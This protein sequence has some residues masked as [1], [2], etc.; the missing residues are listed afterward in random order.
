M[1]DGGKNSFRVCGVIEE[2]MRARNSALGFVSKFLSLP[3]IHEIS[4][5]DRFL[6]WDSGGDD[7]RDE[8]EPIRVGIVSQYFCSHPIGRLSLPL[9]ASLPRDKF[10]VTVFSFPTIVDSWAEAISWSADR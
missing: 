9:I 5:E 3:D 2:A 6:R 8:E 4:A 1:Q 7:E 10:H